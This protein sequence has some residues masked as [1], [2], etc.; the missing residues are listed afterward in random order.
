L[1][2]IANSGGKSFGSSIAKALS[3]RGL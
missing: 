2:A 3:L 1:L